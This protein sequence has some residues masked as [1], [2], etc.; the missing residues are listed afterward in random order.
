M[1]PYY[2]RMNCQPAYRRLDGVSVRPASRSTLLPIVAA[3]VL[4]AT[5]GLVFGQAATLDTATD[6]AT[7]IKPPDEGNCR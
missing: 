1:T 6:V 7:K 4:Q 5:G 2:R 3:L